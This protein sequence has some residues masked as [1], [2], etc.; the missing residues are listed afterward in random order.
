MF[1]AYKIGVRISLINHASMGLAL[2]S[3]DF[4]KT[5]S[6]AQKLESRIK[7][8]KNMMIA[9]GAM[10]A[11]GV[12]GLALF[13]APLEEAKKFQT[14][15]A[16]FTALGLGDATNR[17][18][19]K[20]AKG[21]DIMGSSARDNMVLLREATAIMGDFD[22]AKEVLPLLAKMK[23]GIESVM[24]GGAG[25]NF[26][27][28][29]Q[30]AIK[31]TELRGAVVDRDTGHVDLQKFTRVL[32]MMTQAYVASGGTVKPQDYLA[33]IKTGGVSTKLMSD[34]MFFFGLGH[35]MQESGGSRTGTASMSM[36]Q[37]WAMGRMPQRVAEDMAKVGL[38]NPNAIQYGTTGHIKRVDA[39]GIKDAK[40]FTENPFAWVT[41][42]AV[43]QLAAQGLKGDD[44]NLALA[45]LLGIRTASNLADQ[46]V[47]EQK[48]AE[49]YIER[50]H[51]AQGIDGLYNTGKG[52][53]QGKEIDLHAKWDNLL[54]R[55]GDTVLPL[56]IRA[57][58]RLIPMI[59]NLTGWIDKNHA[60]VKVL[61]G[62]FVLLSGAL[63]FA[64]VVTMATGAIRGLTLAIGGLTRAA[65]GGAMLGGAGAAAGMSRL[66]RMGMGGLAGLKVGGLFALAAGGLDA[67]QVSQDDNLDRK[68]K[69]RAYG[70][71]A[72]GV[73]GGVGGAYIGGAI[74]AAFGGIG[75]IPGALIGGAIGNWLGG[76]GGAAAVALAQGD[77][78]PAGSPYIAQK[79]VETVQVHSEL[80]LDGRTLAEQV[81]TH[82]ARALNRPLGSGMYDLGLGLPPVGMNYAK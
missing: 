21:M 19:V 20:F 17:D 48:L 74:G 15:V 43:P 4:L 77:D 60:K 28:M 39:M 31:T 82:Q 5:E 46:F 1:E 49:R 18:A 35:F 64:G 58:E 68:A 40:L 36:F 41:K 7:S 26:E 62:G 80:K 33:A 9:G 8:I 30:A 32:D 55:L 79:Q 6:D 24:A 3:K 12:G 72:G 27:Q 54:L 10:T 22:H 67:Y 81:S 57:L 76:K 11:I 59:E 42:V 50:A 61:A 25:A 29:F 14:E 69:Q 16:K 34:E 75:A 23:F 70:G 78:K 51:K 56:A 37:N 66:G 53:L 47:R 38:L 65:G 71:V 44:L 63:A 52:T 2:L 13:K 73:A 45:K